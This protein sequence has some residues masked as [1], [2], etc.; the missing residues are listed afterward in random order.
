MKAKDTVMNFKQMNLLRS[1]PAVAEAQA[2]ITWPLAFKAG[3]EQR[4]RDLYEEIICPMCYRL[5]PQH[6]S[7][8]DGKGCNWCQ[9]KEDW[10][11][12]PSSK[13]GG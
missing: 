3:E 5:N 13:R 10:C 12:K 2:E 7:M 11:G 6:A 9:E 8:D 1:T 4:A